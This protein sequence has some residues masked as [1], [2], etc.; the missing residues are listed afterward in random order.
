MW[1]EL[2]LDVVLFTA[3][4]SVYARSRARSVDAREIEEKIQI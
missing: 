2:G 4:L 1:L 3:A